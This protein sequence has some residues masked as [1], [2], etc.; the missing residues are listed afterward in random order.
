MLN[1]V[2]LKITGVPGDS[3][4]SQ[5]HDF[6]P[7]D[8]EKKNLRGHLFAVVS[9][10]RFEEGIDNVTSGRELI[11]RLHEEYFGNLEGK[12]FNALK[13]AVEKV[14]NE[15]SASWGDV[16]VVAMAFVNNVCYCATSGGSQVAILR[17]GALATIL[18]SQGT[19]TVAASGYPKDKDVMV[20]GTKEFFEKIP[21]GIIKAGLQEENVVEA[22]A[23]IL[24]KDQ[25]SGKMASIVV[26]FEEGIL[27][28]EYVS[29][30]VAVEKKIEIPIK[31]K[32][33][34]L[35]SPIKTFLANFSKKAGSFVPERKIYIKNT[36][37]FESED[38][39]KNLTLSVG[40]IL[41]VILVISIA[42]GIKQKNNNELKSQYEGKLI[43]ANQ[44]LDEAVGLALV[45][46]DRARELFVSAQQKLSEME[47]INAKDPKIEELRKKIEE[48]KG[49][50][51]GE[52]QAQT[53]MFLDLT[54]LSSGFKGDMISSS[55]GNLFILDRTG[56]KIVSVEMDTKKSKVVAG[57]DKIG[58][59]ASIA[60][61]SDRVFILDNDGIKEVEGTV[62]TVISKDWEEEALVYGF[63][64]N[65]YVLDKSANQ[66][67]RYSG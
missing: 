6:L 55:Q 50:T 65:L 31:E 8:E 21:H 5:V 52:Y 32:L 58:D 56:K 62:D 2:S 67:Y 25:N 64:G 18:A 12:A 33:T 49:T 54:L 42:F 63:A 27:A 44:N 22:F 28:S 10:R 57:P 29:A 61:Y 30:A 24:H 39:N 59:V 35:G 3:G 16:E 53:N 48:Q 1:L 34:Q 45:S 43:E 7:E 9:T 51:F 17:D 14:T 38:K 47:A 66:V 37:E 26:K 11:S 20:L 15:F 23:P 41:L 40:I 36:S 19:E 4:W 13:L 60:S 46:P